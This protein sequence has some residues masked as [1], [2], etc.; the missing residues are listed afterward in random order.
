MS[1]EFCKTYSQLI[2]LSSDA[3]PDT[4]YSTENYNQLN[5]LGPTL[6]KLEYAFPKSK[7][8]A[9]SDAV[10]DIQLKSIRPPYKFST[11]LKNVQTSQ[12]IYKVKEQVIASVETL[13]QAGVAPS[14]LKFMIKSKVLTDTTSI[15][16]LV[17]DSAA[18]VTITVMVSAPAPQP[19]AQEEPGTIEDDPTESVPLALSEETWNKI[20]A[21]LVADVGSANGKVFLEKF[22]SI[23]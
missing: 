6:P 12:S 7:S 21:L 4:F 17:Q 3:S 5:S 11:T 9:V 8:S 14:N 20:H 23:V 16:S 22:K 15:V 1:V 10:V 19:T 18:D 13:K 2:N